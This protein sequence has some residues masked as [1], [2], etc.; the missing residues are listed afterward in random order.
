MDDELYNVF[1][2]N[3]HSNKQEKILVDFNLNVVKYLMKRFDAGKKDKI[4]LLELGVGKG[5]F[6]QACMVYN[7]KSDVKINYS[8]FDR[9]ID[10]LKNLSKVNKDIKTHRG[11]LPG[12]SIKHKKFDIVYC[13]FVVEHLKNGL[14]VYELINNIKKILNDGGLIVFFTPN[15]LSQRFEFYNIDY[16]HFSDYQPQCD[17]GFQRL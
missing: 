5:Y 7:Q 1:L 3:N 14:E 17:D 15:A 6:A 16:T 11:E 4:E 9:N 13:A 12:L 10:M 2:N 8:A